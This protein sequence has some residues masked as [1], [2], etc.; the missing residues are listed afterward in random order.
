[1]SKDTSFESILTTVSYVYLKKESDCILLL[2]P[3]RNLVD[4]VLDYKLYYHIND[5]PNLSSPNEK[6]NRFLSIRIKFE[7]VDLIDEDINR[8]FS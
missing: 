5:L 1:L 6:N 3:K 8:V 7:M 2:E 4:P